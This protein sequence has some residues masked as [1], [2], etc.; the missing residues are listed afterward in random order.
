MNA[1]LM[2]VVFKFLS[3]SMTSFSRHKQM[4]SDITQLKISTAYLK[5][6]K[7]FRLLFLSLLVIGLMMVLATVGLILVYVSVFVYAPWDAPAKMAFGLLSAAFYFWVVW[8]LS[9][10][11]CPQDVW[12][13]MFHADEMVKNL[14]QGESSATKTGH[15]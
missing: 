8:M 3:G 15:D 9:L 2:D 1:I 12:L 4:Q 10:R 7:T 6:I 11:I 13:K 5:S 14:S